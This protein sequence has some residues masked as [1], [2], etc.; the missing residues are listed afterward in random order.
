[1]AF[2]NINPGKLVQ[3]AAQIYG[4]I[5]TY[6][7]ALGQASLLEEQGSLTRDDYFRQASLV[8]E[9]GQRTRAKQT[10]DYISSGVEAVGTPTLVSKETSLKSTAKAG[11]LDITG[12]NYEKLYNKKAQITKDEG[13]SSMISGAMMGAGTMLETVQW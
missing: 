11:A 2:G 6:Q 5:A 7:S 10:M 13:M 1:M 8:R 4:G 12:R 9:D 3:G